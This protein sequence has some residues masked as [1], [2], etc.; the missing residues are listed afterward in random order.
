MIFPVIVKWC[1]TVGTIDI[2]TGG[3][4]KLTTWPVVPHVYYI[5]GVLGVVHV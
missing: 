4:N 5:G 1:A 2:H 3:G